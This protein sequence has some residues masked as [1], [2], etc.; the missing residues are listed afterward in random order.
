MAILEKMRP[1][2]Y[3]DGDLIVKNQDKAEFLVILTEGI[4]DIL[5]KGNK[6]L[7]RP[8][9][10]ILG[11]NALKPKSFRTADMVAQG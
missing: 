9:P 8:G 3:E 5:V 11:E 4:V 10:C 6:V 1:K 7:E 2:L